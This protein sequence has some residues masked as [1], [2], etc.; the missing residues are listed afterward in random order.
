M[1]R[2][3]TS[4]FFIDVA[5]GNVAGHS[6]VHKFGRNDGVPNGTWEFVNQLGFT[7]WPLSAATT[8]RIKAGGGADDDV[9]GIGA[10]EITVQGI[11]SSFNET[12]ETIATGGE[13]ASLATTTSFWRVHRAWVSAVGTYGGAN[14]NDVVIENSAGG[15]D[16]LQITTGE[17]QTQFAG[18]TTPV[19][20]QA[21]LLSVFATADGLK[22]ADVRM[23]VR[24]EI[25][26]TS[27]PMESKR[28]KLYWD[29]VLGLSSTLNFATLTTP[30]CS[31]AS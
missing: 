7:A 2:S 9:G 11:D 6:L 4:D 5:K 10:T 22:S 23:F 13:F 26:V 20:K 19:G 29:G 8:V 31:S 1:S 27:A 18:W 12:S 3:F 16:L 17:G 15:T 14:D 28:L 25:D 21:Y 30:S 24:K